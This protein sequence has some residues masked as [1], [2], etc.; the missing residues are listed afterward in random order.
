MVIK[1]GFIDK[2]TSA[3]GTKGAGVVCISGLDSGWGAAALF[4]AQK[5]AKCKGHALG[6]KRLLCWSKVG[7]REDL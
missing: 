5:N 2:V 1:T 3:G 7:K 6:V 4:S